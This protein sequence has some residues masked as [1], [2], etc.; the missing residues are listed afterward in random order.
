MNAK[1]L[2]EVEFGIEQLKREIA[3]D[4]RN[5]R[6]AMRRSEAKRIAFKEFNPENDIVISREVFASLNELKTAKNP[7]MQSEQIEEIRE[8]VLF[9]KTLFTESVKGKTPS[10]ALSKEERVN[11]L[12]AKMLSKIAKSKRG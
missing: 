5:G 11:A 7:T 9:L 6:E 12:R 10:K 4:N 8:T 1:I 3:E 2:R